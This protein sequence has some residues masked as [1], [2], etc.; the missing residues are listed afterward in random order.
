MEPVTD[1]LPRVNIERIGELVDYM[2]CLQK[3]LSFIPYLYAKYGDDIL[4][5]YEEACYL[6]DY[7]ESKLRYIRASID[8]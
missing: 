1:T 4:H 6:M 7:T 8:H 2:G 5:E 3:E